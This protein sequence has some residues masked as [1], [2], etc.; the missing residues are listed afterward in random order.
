MA[1]KYIDVKE[2]TVRAHKRQIHTRVFNLLCKQCEQPK[3]RETYGR[4]PLYCE[5]CR[6]TTTTE[7]IEL[8]TSEGR[9]EVGAF[10][11]VLH[12]VQSGVYRACGK[13]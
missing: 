4:E 8:A 2:Y 11:V 3:K 10:L 5:Q 7:K 13:T 12:S 1:C 9:T 6:T